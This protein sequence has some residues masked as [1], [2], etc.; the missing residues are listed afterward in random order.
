MANNC[1]TGLQVS[2]CPWPPGAAW[3][4]RLRHEATCISRICSLSCL[5]FKTTVVLPLTAVVRA[6]L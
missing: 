3:Y 6:T 1:G 2:A 5:Q 4:R